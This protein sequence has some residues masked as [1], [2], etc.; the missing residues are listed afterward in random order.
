[1]GRAAEVVCP[2]K[3]KP[4][5]T[6]KLK[7]NDKYKG[8]FS[9]L[10]K[11]VLR[12]GILVGLILL[13]IQLYRSII[14][15]KSQTLVI[16]HYWALF[17]ALLIILMH[18]F[19]YFE[20]WMILLR[21]VKIS[22]PNHEARYGYALSFLARYI[23]GSVWG[24]LSR[25]EWLWQ[26]YQVNY[27][28]SNFVSILEIIISI[29]S[30]LIATG[31]CYILISSEHYYSV[32]GF[33]L[34]LLPTIFWFLLPTRIPSLQR[35]KLTRNYLPNDWKKPSFLNWLRPLLLLLVCW[36]YDGFVLFLI[37]VSFGSWQLNQWR[38]LWAPLTKV[39]SVAWLSGFLIFF[40]PSGLGV[41]EFVMTS[42]LLTYCQGDVATANGISIAMRLIMT[43]AEL[44][45]L[46][47]FALMHHLKGRQELTNGPT[48]KN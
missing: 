34:I 24:Y 31:L 27:S 36:F 21:A 15:F 42:Q 41:R 20:N 11:I 19:Q 14:D 43:S 17:I 39:F 45:Y 6:M 9:R 33:I 12:L 18:I 48:I 10:R 32:L 8:W 37:G 3:E 46:A 35:Y 38:I 5:F 1:M 25:S 26:K 44:A 40:L 13:S 28:S 16:K 30:N 23:P 7:I 47:I 2:F 4:L 29:V 22:L